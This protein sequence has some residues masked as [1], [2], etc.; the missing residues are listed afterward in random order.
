V[1]LSEKTSKNSAASGQK[2]DQAPVPP[3][4]V[5]AEPGPTKRAKKSGPLGA[6]AAGLEALPAARAPRRGGKRPKPPHGPPKGPPK[7]PHGGP[8]AGAGRKPGPQGRP[9]LGKLRRWVTFRIRPDDRSALEAAAAACGW[10]VGKF[11]RIA[12]LERALG[13]R[14]VIM[15]ATERQLFANAL[16]E[17]RRQGSNLNQIA[18][19]ANKVAKGLGRPS[20]LPTAE[21]LVDTARD[22]KAVVDTLGELLRP[23]VRRL[24]DAAPGGRREPTKASREASRS[25]VK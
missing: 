6:A 2:A 22:V 8:R 23:V 14:L 13:E 19:A 11:A 12:S 21:G 7:G 10:R 25:K 1:I 18:F 20:E 3:A 16:D 15:D 24:S 5:R 4:V 17:L 9:V